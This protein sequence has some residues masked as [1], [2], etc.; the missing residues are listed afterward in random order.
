M[1]GFVRVTRGP[2]GC[3]FHL[4]NTVVQH[5]L[6]NAATYASYPV[7]ACRQRV[8]NQKELMA[9][10]GRPKPPRFLRPALQSQRRQP[11]LRMRIVYT[12][13]VKI[14]GL[15]ANIAKISNGKK[16]TL[17]YHF[18][19]PVVVSRSASYTSG[20]QLL[21]VNATFANSDNNSLLWVAQWCCWW[22]CWILAILMVVPPPLA[23]TLV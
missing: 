22:S 10:M 11:L 5:C 18:C 13:K 21:V 16:K 3:G 14:S 8:R 4:T 23:V 6:Y 19:I 9:K 1:T 12:S 7:D 15:L 2:I 20:Y 17:R